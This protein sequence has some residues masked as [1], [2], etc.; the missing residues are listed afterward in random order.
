[1]EVAGK[2]I[3]VVGVASSG[4]AAARL[5]A[6]RGARVTANDLKAEADLMKSPLAAEIE[7]LQQ[8]GVQFIFGSHPE[9]IFLHADLIILSP[10]VPLTIAPLQNSK[11]AG[12]EII[13]EPELAGRFLR[14]RMIG[15]TGSNGKT[16]TN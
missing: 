5:L 12:V 4:L 14:G 11:L 2:K 13:S 6:S 9:G 16:T 8:L 15:I 3:L 1:M 7:E 10:G